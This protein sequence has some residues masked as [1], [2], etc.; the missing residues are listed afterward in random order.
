MSKAVFIAFCALLTC[1]SAIAQQY[2]HI[3]IGDYRYKLPASVGLIATSGMDT[4]TGTVALQLVASH[5]T[6]TLLPS[7]FGSD[8][9]GWHDSIRI[10]YQSVPGRKAI[11]G[12]KLLAVRLS[13][14]WMSREK[15]HVTGSGFKVFEPTL[16]SFDEVWTK[17]LA[18]GGIFVMDC[19]QQGWDIYPACKVM[20]WWQG[21]DLSYS[22]SRRY[23]DDAVI[24][25]AEVKKLLTSYR[26]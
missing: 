20:E 1:S 9:T 24:I 10:L 12:E 23:V 19:S 3:K 15:F 13:N 14:P 22:F 6:M 7:G 8:G 16:K 26:E 25:D 17:P 11:S 5:P 18:D 2:R 21:A 4:P